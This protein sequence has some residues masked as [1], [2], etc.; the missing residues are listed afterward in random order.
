MNNITALYSGTVNFLEPDGD[1]TGIYKSPI[2][3]ACIDLNGIIGD[4]Q[5]DKRFH[6]GPE[7]ALHQFALTSY[8]TIIEQ[9][10]DLKGIAIPGSIG[11][12]LNSDNLN[13]SNVCIG[14]TY[15]LG[16]IL[17][18]VS[19][20]RRPCWKI[21]HKFDVSQLA[22]FIAQQHITGWYYRVL[23]P[24]NVQIGDNITLVDH[25][26]NSLTVEEL[27]RI[28]LEHRPNPEALHNAIEC[29]GLS[30]QWQSG[31]IQR[32]AYLSEKI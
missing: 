9:F 11:E 19:Q 5:V 26:K 20:P 7:K 32:A 25:H 1:K 12:N 14:D 2:E 13:D 21:N 30:H 15:K 16:S 8:Q 28:T 24:G 22:K 17:I 27:S 29:P 31:L 23:E 4:V 6:G 18:Q 10:P 3:K